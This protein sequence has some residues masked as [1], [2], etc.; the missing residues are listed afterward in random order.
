MENQTIIL[1]GSKTD[2]RKYTIG[3]GGGPCMSPQRDVDGDDLV[4][5]LQEKDALTD[6]V[7]MECSVYM[8]KRRS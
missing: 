1:K 2:K 8:T 7:P 4:S 6:P 5:Q 3:T